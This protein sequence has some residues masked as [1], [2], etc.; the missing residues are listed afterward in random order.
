MTKRSDN[1]DVEKLLSDYC[2]DNS[3]RG[4][5][6]LLEK[7]DDIDMSYHD[8]IFFRLAISN[9]SVVMLKLLIDYF[10]HYILGKYEIGSVDYLISKN[11]LVE[12]LEEQIDFEDLGNEMHKILE[13]YER[14]YSE[15]EYFDEGS[16]AD[17]DFSVFGGQVGVGGGLQHSG[18]LNVHHETNVLGQ[19]ASEIHHVPAH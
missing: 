12:I 18:N 7:Y 16:F 17:A 3:L 4:V 8:G 6:K 10:E 9:N 13:P 14:Q 2:Q 1:I 15:G 19:N 5:Q 11:H